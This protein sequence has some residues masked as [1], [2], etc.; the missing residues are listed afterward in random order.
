MDAPH[1]TTGGEK[2]PAPT[3]IV[4]APKTAEIGVKGNP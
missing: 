3:P 2:K 4:I 1:P